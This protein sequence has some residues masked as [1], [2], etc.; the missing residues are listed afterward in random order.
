MADVSNFDVNSV[1]S[2]LQ[3]C[4]YLAILVAGGSPCQ[5]VASARTQLFHA[6][7]EIAES[8]GEVLRA[9]END[10]PGLGPP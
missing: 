10:H 5:D 8:C 1:R 4:K 3:S 2:L 7:P 6:L 9:L